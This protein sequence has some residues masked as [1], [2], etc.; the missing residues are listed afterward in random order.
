MPVWLISPTT[1]LSTVWTLPVVGGGFV[2]LWQL[3]WPSHP[4]S[5]FMERK[6]RCVCVGGWGG[7]RERRTFVS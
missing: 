3:T 1:L 2:S 6:R 4:S 5:D 7:K